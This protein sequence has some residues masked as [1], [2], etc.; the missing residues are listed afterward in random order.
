MSSIFDT[1]G[2]PTL[3]LNDAK[4][5]AWNGDGTY[6]SL[7]DIP[8]VQMMGVTL[9]VTSAELEGDDQITAVGSRVTKGTAKIRFGSVNLNAMAVI[10]GLS[11]NSSGSGGGAQDAMTF[12]A[13]AKLPYFGLCGK[14]L[15]EEGAGDLHVFLPKCRITSDVDLANLEYNKFAITEFTVTFVSDGDFDLVNFVEHNTAV[16]ITMP[17]TGIS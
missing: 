3:G 4:V 7:V 11:K 2:A 9:S 14:A 5:G 17:P 6:G 16:S 1:Q 8:S 13:G 15:A 10:F 12:T